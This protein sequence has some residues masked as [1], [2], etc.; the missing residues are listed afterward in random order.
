MVNQVVYVQYQLLMW[1]ECSG[2]PRGS[3][4]AGTS[5]AEVAATGRLINKIQSNPD[6]AQIH[7]ADARDIIGIN[8]SM[9]RNDTTTATNTSQTDK[10]EITTSISGNEDHAG[11]LASTESFPE[12]N[13]FW[14]LLSPI[15]D[16]WME[17]RCD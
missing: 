5:P 9:T 1:Q 14:T 17:F 2:P 16:G 7:E 11:S 10:S 8:N 3:A 13:Q 4:Q 15:P 6:S 12:W